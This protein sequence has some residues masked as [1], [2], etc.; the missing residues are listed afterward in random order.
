[1]TPSSPGTV[2]KILWH[3]TGGPKWDE[4]AYRQTTE[5][6]P[7]ED[8]YTATVNILRTRELRV[9]QTKEV[10]DMLF[11]VPKEEEKVLP[12]IIVEHINKTP[13]RVP[14][15]TVNCLA[16]IPIMHLGYHSERYG[17]IALGFHREAVIKHGFSPVFYQL[18]HSAILQSLLSGLR[19]V[20]V[21]RQMDIAHQIYELGKAMRTL[22]GEA[23]TRLHEDVMTRLRG[24]EDLVPVANYV[25]A[26]AMST[27]RTILSFVKSFPPDG[28]GTIY[29]EREWRS[30]KPFH[31]E[32]AD[33]SMVVLPREGGYFGRFVDES[34][35]IGLPK[36]VSVVAWEDLV[37][38]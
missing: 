6:R 31:F 32:Y 26:E 5:P 38:H 22:E 3:F 10:V 35:S 2:S 4:N 24:L 8:A 36:T 33:V 12:A 7:V 20:D 21:G 17:K 13:I 30:D 28:F 15:V 11:P 19:A 1:V 37:E 27:L 23:V 9:G 34:Q 16:D 25:V 14:T 29:C 18:Q